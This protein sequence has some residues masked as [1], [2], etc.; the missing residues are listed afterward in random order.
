[1]VNLLALTRA[2]PNLDWTAMPW[3]TST[4]AR[5]AF[6]GQSLGSIVGLSFGAALP[7]PAEI[8]APTA[9]P[10]RVP[11]MVLSVPGGGV[12]QLLRDSPTF[13]PRINNGLASQ[14]LLPGTSL[15]EQYF[16]DVQNIVDAGD[17]AQLRHP[18]RRAALYL[19]P[20]DGGWRWDAGGI[21]GPGDPEFGPRNG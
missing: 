1:V 16:R 20:A 5:I 18:D 12:A 13:G 14:G 3:A 6:V 4:P 9:S 7:I 17:P 2:L 21:A 15:Y 11:T 8:P 19:L 10:L